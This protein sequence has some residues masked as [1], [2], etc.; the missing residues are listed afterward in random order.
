MMIY[1]I[2]KKS[3]AVGGLVLVLPGLVLLGLGLW[4]Y[5]GARSFVNNS[6]STEG[7]VVKNATRSSST[8][9]IFSP[10][11]EFSDENGNR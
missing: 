3:V 7:R 5:L 9:V 8:G 10:V 1:S 11:F 4:Q 2:L 6:V